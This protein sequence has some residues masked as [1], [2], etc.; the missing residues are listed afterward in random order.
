MPE[1]TVSNADLKAMLEKA[2]DNELEEF[3][4]SANFYQDYGLDS[5][6]AVV[7]FVELQRKTGIEVDTE[8]APTLQTGND[9]AKYVEALQ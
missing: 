3:D 6:G 8:L 5:M 4:M 7:L 1:R 9:V 2:L